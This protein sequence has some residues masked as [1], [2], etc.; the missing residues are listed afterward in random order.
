MYIFNINL[1]LNIFNLVFTSGAK[2]E[3]MST[4]DIQEAK[5]IFECMKNKNMLKLTSKCFNQENRLWVL[6]FF[7]FGHAVG[8]EFAGLYLTMLRGEPLIK[9]TKFSIKISNDFRSHKAT[10]ISKE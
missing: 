1:I 3:K 8:N 6:N 4:W 9:S 5:S 2:K 7:P 10:H